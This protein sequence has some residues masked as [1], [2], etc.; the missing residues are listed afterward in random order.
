MRV[1]VISP[2]AAVFDGEA[3]SVSAPAFDGQVGILPRHA[4]FMTLLGEGQLVVRQAGGA[5]AFRVKGGF[6]QVVDDRVRV[7]AEQV[8]GEELNA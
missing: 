4:P 3:E 8:Q 1:T 7:V 2:E 6:L 5:R